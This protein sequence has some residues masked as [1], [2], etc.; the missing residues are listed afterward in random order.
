[1]GIL[2]FDVRVDANVISALHVARTA[3]IVTV[4]KDT[5]DVLLIYVDALIVVHSEIGNG[6]DNFAAF[7][8]D[9]VHGLTI[10]GADYVESSPI[11]A[12]LPICKPFF[13][14]LAI[15]AQGR[16]RNRHARGPASVEEV[17]GLG[18][19][20]LDGRACDEDE[21]GRPPPVLEFDEVGGGEDDGLDGS[22]VGEGVEIRV[23]EVGQDRDER[24]GVVA[25]VDVGVEAAEHEDVLEVLGL[26]PENGEGLVLS[27]GVVAGPE[28]NECEE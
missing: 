22:V 7:A 17:V 9:D 18:G 5:E 10:V 3:E 2:D 14:R 27:A 13:G 25:I 16:C 28:K 12:N 4:S 19:E 21:L 1:M 24:R 15:V 11:D 26:A 8:R 20:R 23:G 6:Q